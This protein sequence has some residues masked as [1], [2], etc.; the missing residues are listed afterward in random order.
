MLK[1]SIKSYKKLIPGRQFVRF[2]QNRMFIINKKSFFE[3]RI[4]VNYIRKLIIFNYA[5]YCYFI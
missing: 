4:I 5:I 1:A 3:S 2:N